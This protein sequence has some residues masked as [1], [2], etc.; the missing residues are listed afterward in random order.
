MFCENFKK[1]RK[2]SGMTQEEVAKFLMVTP[3]AVS[4][5]ETGN[6]TPDISLLV[7]IAELFGIST[8]NLLGYA[9]TE[10]LS[11]LDELYH[12]TQETRKDLYDKYIDLL[13]SNPTNETILSRLLSLTA[14]R[15]ASAK[16]NMDDTE[17]EELVSAAE[18]FASRLQA[19]KKCSVLV[20]ALGKLADVYIAA[21]DFRQAKEKIDGLPSNRYTKNRM[22]GNMALRE[23]RPEQGIEFYRES[24]YDT[25]S[26][27][28]WDIERIAQCYG[29]TLR[30][31]FVGIRAKMDEIYAIEYDLI[32][33]IGAEGSPLLKTY[34]C[35][36]SIR[37]AQKAIRDN[38]YEKAFDY[39]DEFMQGVSELH[40]DTTEKNEPCSPVLPNQ[41]RKA[42]PIGKKSVLHRLSWNSFNPIR[43]DPRFLKYIEKAN[44][45]R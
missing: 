41:F 37:L 14:E 29:A 36:A 28:L 9:N 20:E 12:S 43:N 34:L 33:A 5:W 11:A 25:V 6:G 27:L 18:D 21:G 17:K 15:L 40:D 16:E 32:H 30:D 8:D 24:V 26:F 2:R 19:D 22:L 35:N 31:D 7:P 44:A 39:L 45:W 10:Q 4:K 3:Q 13:K 38:E 23:K 1:Y 42:E